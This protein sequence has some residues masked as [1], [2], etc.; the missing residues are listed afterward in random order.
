MT[1]QIDRYVNVVSKII[2]VLSIS[3]LVIH[4]IFL[5][6]YESSKGV[7]MSSLTTH[8]IDLKFNIEK[9]KSFILKSEVFQLGSFINKFREGKLS[10]NSVREITIRDFKA[11]EK[12]INSYG[13]VMKLT[14]NS[15]IILFIINF[16]LISF[17]IFR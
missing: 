6:K 15:G 16:L 7:Y 8:Y 2:F 11:L 10:Y 17:L 9:V 5:V 12:K 1:N 4:K 13:N 14:Y 3:I